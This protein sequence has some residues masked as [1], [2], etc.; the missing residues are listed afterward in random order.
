MALDEDPS[1]LLSGH[2]NE[3]WSISCSG[4]RRSHQHRHASLHN[5][6][7]ADHHIGEPTASVCS[8]VHAVQISASEVCGQHTGE[9]L[10]LWLTGW[11]A[12]LP[13][14]SNIRSTRLIFELDSAPSMLERK[15]L[16]ASRPLLET[17]QLPGACSWT[18]ERVRDGG[19]N[20]AVHKVARLFP[21]LEP[22]EANRWVQKRLTP[23]GPTSPLGN[24]YAPSLARKGTVLSTVH[25]AITQNPRATHTH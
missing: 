14:P 16:Q 25:C 21:R 9:G 8:V 18:Y 22:S 19:M 24:R 23:C 6:A 17:S 15:G 7:D 5:H 4:S 11:R 20:A 2:L 3:C 13:K 12:A 10:G 1:L